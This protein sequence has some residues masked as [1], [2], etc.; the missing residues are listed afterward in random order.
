MT[1]LSPQMLCGAPQLPCASAEVCVISGD[2]SQTGVRGGV[3]Q[4]TPTD[5]Q[6]EGSKVS[7]LCVNV[8]TCLF[9]KMIYPEKE[10]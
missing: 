2:E 7:G 3:T 6:R 5:G 4:I 8:C 10:H 1:A 9:V